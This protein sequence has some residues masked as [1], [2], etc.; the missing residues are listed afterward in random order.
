MKVVLSPRANKNLK[1]LPSLLKKKFL[2]Q[3]DYL[4]KNPLHPSLRA[5]KMSGLDVYEARIDYHYRFVYQTSR[6]KIEIIALGP[7]DEGLGKK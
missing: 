7:H 1:K 5:R 4:T 3:L 2:K 6:E